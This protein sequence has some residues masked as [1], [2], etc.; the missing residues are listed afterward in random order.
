V[1]LNNR[2]FTLIEVVVAMGIMLVGLLGLLAT[3]NMA[4]EFNTRDYLRNEA[5]RIGERWINGSRNIAYDN[6][7]S[8]TPPGHTTSINIRGIAKNYTVNRTVE[9]LPNSRHISV[10]VS[11]TYKGVTYNHG[12]DSVVAP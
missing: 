5:V 9:Q 10:V 4:T 11:W 3:A 12:V 1:T 2:G 8:Y 6:I 7:S